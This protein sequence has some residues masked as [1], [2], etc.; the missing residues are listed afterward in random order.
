M[1]AHS[2]PLI[3]SS[4]FERDP[5][6]CARD[7]IGLSLVH[8]SCRGIVIETE[9][10][11]EHGD[12][13]CHLFTRPSA[14]RFA[15]DHPAGTAYVYLNYGIHWLANVLCLDPET[16]HAGFVLLRALE[17]VEGIEL[18][19]QRRRQEK[20]AALCS[21]P[22]KL[23]QAMGFDRSD[24]GRSF[25]ESGDFCFREEN[26]AVAAVV[27]DR[28]IGISAAKDLPW[29]FLCAGHPGVSVPFG[30]AR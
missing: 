9:A 1:K 30:K 4:F 21:G 29:R 26:S 11:A 3:D 13:A 16:G 18:M 6:S 15:S 25:C 14:R 28:R 2:G 24:H 8:G 23:G 7:L 10:Y 17:P 27:A 20:P 12:E 22:G 19:R 5:V